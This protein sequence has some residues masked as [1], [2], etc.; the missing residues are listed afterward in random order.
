MVLAGL[1]ASKA[2]TGMSLASQTFLFLGAG[3]A[4]A[5]IADL[6][7][8][9]IEEEVRSDQQDP[10]RRGRPNRPTGFHACVKFAP[11]CD[12]G[13][14]LATRREGGGVRDV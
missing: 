11:P 9:A 6:I 12:V 3:E 8:F 14:V 7:A 1:I 5:G 4:G 10:K 2:I 13:I